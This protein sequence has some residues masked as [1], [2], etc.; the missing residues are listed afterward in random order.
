MTADTSST[1]TSLPQ[2]FDTSL[3][4][5]FTSPG[6]PTFFNDFLANSTFQSC[7]PLSLLLQ[8]SSGFFQDTASVVRT[9]Q[10]LDASCNVNVAAC[11]SLMDYYATEITKDDNCGPDY[12]MNNPTVV[13]AYEG[14]VAYQPVYQAGCLKAPS[15]SYC[16]AN[17]ITNASSPTDS[18][19]Y[20]LPLGV[21]LP[22]G[23]RPTCNSC[24]KMTMNAL[25]GYTSNSTQPISQ[26][27][28]DAASQ[29][30]INCGPTFINGTNAVSR[31]GASV[32]SGPSGLSTAVA[33]L[34]ILAVLFT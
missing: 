16:F 18:Y 7:V 3:G 12:H 24:L 27:Y 33:L 9:T 28:S 23:S 32:A 6:C 31:S 1:S 4:S 26:T 14:L 19:P 17:A 2:P 13:E 29:V 22:G 11:A 5:N 30:N 10:V 20:Y 21:A 8:T 34:A 15:G 25:W